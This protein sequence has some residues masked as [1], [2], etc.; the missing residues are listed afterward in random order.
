MEAVYNILVVDDDPAIVELV[1]ETLAGVGM[2]IVPCTDA[3][4]ALVLF[5]QTPVDLVMLDVMM[6]GIDGFEL[7]YQIRKH[8]HVPVIFLSAK[9]EEADKVLGLMSGADDYI[10]KPFLP[11][12]LVARVKS[13]LRRASYAA[14]PVR[15]DV[16]A[17]RGIEI[18][19]TTHRASLHGTELTLT[20]KE[21]DVL[22]L[23]LEAHGKPVATSELYEKVWGEQFLASSANSVMVHIRHLRTK[24]SKLDSDQ[25]F[26]ETVWGVGYKIAPYGT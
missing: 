21:F 6:P 12:E 22:A 11:R 15:E 25:V 19:R 7:C 14:M 16:V 24:L 17:C 8:S 1:G 20:P 4:Q 18:N 23:L 2:H 10:T 13:C 5:E 3:T 9:G 26:I